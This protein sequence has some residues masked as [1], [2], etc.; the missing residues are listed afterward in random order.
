MGNMKESGQKVNNN[1]GGESNRAQYWIFAAVQNN[2]SKYLWST[3][4]P[5]LV[6]DDSFG[7]R[8]HGMFE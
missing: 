1:G 8:Y 3:G 7:L 2:L 6:F 4:F 5:G